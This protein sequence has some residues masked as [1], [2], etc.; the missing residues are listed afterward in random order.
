MADIYIKPTPASIGAA[1][2]DS[3]SFTGTPTAP[4]AALG[5]DTTQIA[6]MAAVLASANT[7][8]PSVTAGTNAQYWRGDKTWQDLFSGVRTATLTGLSTATNAA[9]TAADTV[10]SALGKVQA[11]ITALST[12][13]LDAS[14][15]TAADVRT[16]MAADAAASMT[17]IG[18]GTAATQ[19]STAFATAAQGAKADSAL[20]II[21]TGFGLVAGGYPQLYD[22]TTFNKKAGAYWYGPA[23]GSGPWGLDY[24]VVLAL[25]YAGDRQVRLALK[26]SVDRM[27]IGSI[28]SS[29][30][31][32]WNNL[33]LDARNNTPKTDITYT[34]G[35]ATHR[36]SNGFFS[37]FTVGGGA[38]NADHSLVITGVSGRTRN[39]DFQTN[40]LTRFRLGLT[41]EAEGGSNAGSNFRL[42]AYTD[43]GAYNF[44]TISVS[45]ATGKWNFN[46]RPAIA[47]AGDLESRDAKG[48]ANGYASLDGSG[49]VPA[50][51]LPVAGSYKGGWDASA[52]APAITAGTGTN[53]DYYIV[54]VA[55]TS[56]VT[57]SSTAFAVGDQVRFNG[58]VWGRI[59]N[60]QSVPSVNGKT[61]PVTLTQDDIGEGSTYKQYSLAEKT[62]LGAL[63]NAA[64]LQTYLDAKA[65]LS[66]PALT[67]TPTSPTAAV[68][69][70]TDQIATM[71][72]I[73][74]AMAAVLTSE[75]LTT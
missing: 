53:G 14:A 59:P 73:Q 10:L 7:K 70:N 11:Q 69:T 34:L 49:K 37:N 32:T 50:A 54:V 40:G 35:D 9:I 41:N 39:V 60:A 63:P 48:V 38:E 47:G 28:D 72:A 18:L 56:T 62:K 17:A 6:T 12:G 30:A 67:G 20:Q 74:A 42:A 75:I 3:P 15:Y 64:N 24:G 71:A 13:K 58:T 23:S 1:T 4:T 29:G 61:G 25:N 21:D 65:S 16:K 27:A 2:S 51:Q 44:E 55:G 8:E 68:G 5:T 46:V 66:S 43:A 52:N 57:G 31:Q 22:F 36:F 33:W 26:P 19:A 45:R